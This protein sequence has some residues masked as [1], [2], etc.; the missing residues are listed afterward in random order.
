MC[1]MQAESTTSRLFAGRQPRMAPSHAP[2]VAQAAR[3]L[4]GVNFNSNWRESRS[5]HALSLFLWPK[6]AGQ[7]VDSSRPRRFQLA[8]LQAGKQPIVMAKPRKRSGRGAGASMGHENCSPLQQGRSF[9]QLTPKIE[10]S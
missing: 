3:Q 6:Q 5:F 2:V 4:S 8:T 7:P 1:N 9:P 10:V